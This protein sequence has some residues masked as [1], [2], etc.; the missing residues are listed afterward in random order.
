M[1]LWLKFF[2]A[3]LVISLSPARLAAAD[4]KPD[5]RLITVTGEAEVLVVPD[6]V[7][8][9]LTVQ[10]LNKDLRAAKAQTD[11]RLKKLIDLTRR[12]NVAPKDVQ[13]DYIK[14]EPRYRGNDEGRLFLGY[15]VRKDLVFTLR[16][17]S[18]AEELL[19]E[20]MESAVTRIN[21][22]RFQTSQMRKY[23]D[24]ARGLAI[25]AAQE[26][27]VALTAEIGQKI[28]RAYSIEEESSRGISYAQ[29]V[30]SNAVG[31]AGGEGGDSEGTLSL[32]QIKVSA[33]VTVRFELL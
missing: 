10:T 3:L 29:N 9:D 26:K 16:D 21:G 13:T 19:S 24:Q 17:V 33:R 5:P 11:E 2:A 15:S 30:S 28:G 27:A 1:K 12:Y 6:E 25:R 18:R 14:L 7:V 8:F 20:V 23:R 32:G 31:F 22:V 4:D